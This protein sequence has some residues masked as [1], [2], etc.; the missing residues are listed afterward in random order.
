MTLIKSISGFRGTI[1]GKKGENLT[2]I[3]I[4]E[5]TAGFCTWLNS[6]N[7]SN[8]KVVV[9]RDARPSGTM[10]HQFVNQTLVSMGFEVIDAGLSTT[11]TVEMAIIFEGAAGGIMISASHNP[12][13]WNALKFFN[14]EGEFI[15]KEAGL[16]ILE[17]TA[18]QNFQ[19]VEVDKLGKIIPYDQGIDRH[20]DAILEL[21][22]VHV[23][24]I[25]RANYKVVADC[26]NSTGSISI[27]PLLNRLGVDYTLLNSDLSG[28]FVHDPEPLPKNLLQLSKKVIEKKA[29]LG[30]AV[31]PDVDRLVMV[32]EDGKMLG[33]E[34]TIVALAD[35]LLKLQP[36]N[37][38]SNLSS[39]QA[40]G[41]ITEK[42]GGKYFG[43]PVGEVNVVKRMKEV[44]AVFGGEGNGGVIFPA[45]H[46]GRDA[47]V[48]IALFLSYMAKSK[49]KMSEIRDS[50]PKYHISKKKISL[51][52]TI[53]PDEILEKMKKKYEDTPI[54]TEDGL[55]IFFEAAWVH[56]RK[57][58]TEPIIRIYAESDTEMNAE[59]LANRFIQEIKSII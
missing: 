26:I 36:G 19:F 5:S 48:G 4:V 20:I 47:L 30:I 44:N 35:Y 46:Y 13:I 41:Q 51:D 16:K 3:D 11:P 37:T 33:E 50:L 58:N 39:T 49:L 21:D 17:F 42:Y 10:V 59:R 57:S 12:K 18:S 28:E 54:N 7:Q 9:G 1:G 23:S 8:R 34:Y 52:K 56:M 32:C 55:K 27:A 53:Q 29:D 6:V 45:L 25:K 2:P 40:L 38:V 15:S 43:S 14:Q 22:T 24:A 31:D